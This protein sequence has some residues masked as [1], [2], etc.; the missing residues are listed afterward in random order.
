MIN[1][2]KPVKEW[3]GDFYSSAK[4]AGGVD[5][6]LGDLWDADVGSRAEAVSLV[7]SRANSYMMWLIGLVGDLHLH[8]DCVDPETR[9]LPKSKIDLEYLHQRVSKADARYQALLVESGFNLKVRQ[10]S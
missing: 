5:S 2:Y 3:L 7:Q 10:P 6:L 9:E 1:P 4:D 8:F